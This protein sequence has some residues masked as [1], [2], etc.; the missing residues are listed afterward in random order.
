[1]YKITK[2]PKKNGKASR[3]N[4][5]SSSAV[6]SHTVDHNG[7]YET[8]QQPLCTLNQNSHAFGNDT[9]QLPAIHAT[10]T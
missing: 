10:Y 3:H 6:I 8:V 7:T 2:Q 5:T 9:E 4:T 1:M